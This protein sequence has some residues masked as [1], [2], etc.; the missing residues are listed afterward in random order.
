[1]AIKELQTRIALKYDTYENWHSET[2]GNDKGA[3]LVLLAGELGICEVSTTNA[4]SNEAPTVLFKVGGAK[5]PEGHE[6]AGQLM[7]F[8]DLPWASAKAADVFSW[9]KAETV[10]LTEKTEKVNDEDVKKQYLEFKTGTTIVHSI[11]LSNFATDAEV[12]EVRLSLATRIAELES[13]FE[14]DDS[15]GN[16]F[17]AIKER[18]DVIEGEDEG[19]I[20]KALADAKDYTDEAFASKIGTAEDSKDETTVYGAIAKVKADAAEDATA[21]VNGLLNGQVATNAAA[22]AELRT[23]DTHLD[24]RLDRVE[25]FFDGA[26]RDEGEGENLKNALDTLIEI[27]EYITGDG[28]AAKDML[29]AINTNAEDIDALESIVGKAADGETP[30]TGLVKAVADNAA[31]IASNATDISALQGRAQ[32]LEDIVEGYTGKKSIHDRVEAVSERAEKGITDAKSAQDDIDAL[33]L[34]VGHETTGLAATYTI[35]TNTAASLAELTGASGRVKAAE[36]AIDALE[37]IVNDSDKGNDKLRAD[38]DA[39]QT[40]TGDTT[41]GN[42]ALYTELAR[43]AGLVDHT[44]TGLAKTKAIADEALEDA[45]DAQA[46]VAAIEVDYLKGADYYIFNCGSATTINHIMPEAN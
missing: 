5:Y 19:S 8:K 3:N 1:M 10:S 7:A 6:K 13:K 29:D 45:E 40:L 37:R 41:K 12:E 14:G 28:Q 25:A 36:D 20:K 27:Q 30:A 26:A 42:E 9:A 31:N 38:V 35:A 23:A 44:E 39:L 33:E 24:E 16:T 22:I 15:V 11:D 2:L 21:K 4:N 18:L 17:K 34:V 32:T 43:V 46:R